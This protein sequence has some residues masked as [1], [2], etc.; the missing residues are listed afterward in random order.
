M[1]GGQDNAK[2]DLIVAVNDIFV[3]TL[4]IRLV[5]QMLLLVK[6]SECSFCFPCSCLSMRCIAYLCNSSPLGFSLPLACR[7]V[8]RDML[9]HG[10]F[11]QVFKCNNQ[12]TGEAVAIKIIKNQAAYYHQGRVEIG[13]LQFLN[14]KADPEDRANIVRL[15]D[16][17]QYNGH[18]CL[19]FELL[20]LNLFELVR[21]NKFR[22]LSVPLV[23]VFTR[24]VLEAMTVLRHSGIIH[25]DIKPENIL[26]GNT[27]SGKVKLIDF[28]SACF[29]NRT[30]Y[31][32]I[33]SRFYRSP[34]VV[35]GHAYNMSVDMWSL[36]CVAAELFLGLPLFP[37]ACEHDL[38]GRILE[39]LGPMPHHLLAEGKNTGKFFSRQP[40]ALD[41]RP[42][43]RLMTVD[44]FEAVNGKK[45][46]R[47]KQ[48][49]QHKAL[50]DII[51]AYPMK[52]GLS[53][54]AMQLERQHREAFT[55]FLLGLLDVNPATR[56]TPRQALQ[57]PFITGTRFAGPYQPAADYAVPNTAPR[58]S[59]VA[60]ASAPGIPM[61]IPQPRPQAGAH[62]SG[63]WAGQ[64]AAMIAT[65]PQVHAQAHAA[66]MAAVQM[67]MSLQQA[68]AH[69]GSS[70]SAAH[71]LQRIVNPAPISALGT[72]PGGGSWQGPALGSSLP[73]PMFSPPSRS[74]GVHL[75]Q[76]VRDVAPSAS[77]G[78]GGRI[79]PLLQLP[80]SQGQSPAGP[81]S[82]QPSSVREFHAAMAAV[83]AARTSGRLLPAP[84][85]TPL[86]SVRAQVAEEAG[87]SGMWG[88]HAMAVDKTQEDFSFPA[89]TPTTVP[90]DGRQSAEGSAGGTPFKERSVSVQE[91]GPNPADWDPLW[92]CANFSL[93]THAFAGSRVLQSARACD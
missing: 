31:S 13:I 82:F 1:P 84:K 3:S 52:Q 19:V 66:A 39:M 46:P 15:K 67:Q 33:Q 36:G 2:D 17:F 22:G 32:Y 59:G 81:S 23:R 69:P 48:Y 86:G 93:P 58:T 42:V 5:H 60:A 53:D 49:F 72:T 35:L 87:G 56:W 24:Q 11:G 89:G 57:H 61:M 25:C 79:M 45:A 29:A 6:K 64:M 74:F 43:F 16:F 83:A 34:E 40:G 4:G 47:G 91:D 75:Q 65:S 90:I 88:S 7:Y 44:E 8:V 55:D 26:L 78:D 76:A 68:Q 54:E 20:S 50:A 9:G 71:S 30:V 92:R 70:Y 28:G 80:T 38:L 85:T 41:D 63:S 73:A 18:L 12:A 27:T 51:S 37:A 21:H 77:P 10:T 62:A 14:T